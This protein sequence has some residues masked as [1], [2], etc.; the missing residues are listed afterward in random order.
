MRQAKKLRRQEEL[1][2]ETYGED[3]RKYESSPS[4]IDAVP[5]N[6]TAPTK[7]TRG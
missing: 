3:E 1:P 4:V 6:N 7:E 2:S 5:I